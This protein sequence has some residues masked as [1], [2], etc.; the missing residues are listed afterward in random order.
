MMHEN[1]TRVFRHVNDVHHQEHVY[2]R[3]GT[4]RAI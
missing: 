3:G 2:R 4:V 1:E